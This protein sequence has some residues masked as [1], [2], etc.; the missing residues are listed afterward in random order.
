MP[1]NY[2]PDTWEVKI[3]DYLGYTYTKKPITPTPKIYYCPSATADASQY[4][5]LGQGDYG[6]NRVLMNLFGDYEF[7]RLSQVNYAKDTML[8]SDYRS[9]WYR[10]ISSAP[11]LAHPEIWRHQNGINVGFVDGHAE[12][13][14]FTDAASRG[15]FEWNNWRFG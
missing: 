11:L 9:G 4:E 3:A 15:Y 6:M 8:V 7:I 5:Y 2:I 12:W 14:S 13:T 1:S 10:N